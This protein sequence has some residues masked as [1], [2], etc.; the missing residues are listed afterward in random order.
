MDS[1]TILVSEGAM[2]DAEKVLRSNANQK[3]TDTSLQRRLYIL[4]Y[5]IYIKLWPG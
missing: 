5:Q 4:G 1:A 3:N 2:S